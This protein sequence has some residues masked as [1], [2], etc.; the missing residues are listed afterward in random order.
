MEAHIHFTIKLAIVVWVLYKVW[1]LL[2]RDRLFGLWDRLLTPKAPQQPAPVAKAATVADPVSIMGPS[3]R[4]ILADPRKPAEPQPV[5]TTDLE[6]TGFIGEEQPPSPDEIEAPEPPYIPSD[7]ELDIPPP[8]DNELF[9]SGVSFDDLDNVFDVLKNGS[10]DETRLVKAAKTAYDI[11]N[12]EI[13]EMLVSEVCRE[14]DIVRLIE[15]Y[16]DTDGFPLPR[17]S[18]I[19]DFRIEDYL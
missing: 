10:R 7:D 13:M 4:V 12:T 17:R 19:A 3:K 1:L 9:S 6:P 2:F 15:G 11:Q 8:D 16:L 14:A 5:A 18:S